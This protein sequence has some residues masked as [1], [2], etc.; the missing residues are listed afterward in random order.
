VQRLLGPPTGF[1]QRREVGADGD[2]GDLELDG[3]DPGIPRAGAVT[4]A[5]G[6]AVL[7][8]FVGAGAD[9]GADLD[10]HDHLTQRLDAFS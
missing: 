8:A 4:V 3:A 1:E 6:G 10:I 9:L 2:L 5:V 7:G